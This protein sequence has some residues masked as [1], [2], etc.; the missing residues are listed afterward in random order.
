MGEGVRVRTNK[1]LNNVFP[2][3]E[4]KAEVITHDRGGGGGRGITIE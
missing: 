3:K 2:Y 4:D 1:E